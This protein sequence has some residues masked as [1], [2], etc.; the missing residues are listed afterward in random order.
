MLTNYVKITFRNLIRNK[1]YSAVNIGGL[2]I[3]MAVTILIG[4]WLH[5]ELTFNRAFPKHAR[6][7]Q[8]MATQ[9]VNGETNTADAIPIP[10]AD[11]LRINHG[12]ALKRVAL[13]FPPF[14][15]ILSVGEKQV[16]QSGIWAQADLPDML[17]FTMLRGRRDALT[18]PSSVLLA[19]SL[20]TSLFGSAEPMGKLIKLDNR[21]YVTVAGVFQ[22]FPRNT[23][24][25]E[26]KL[27]LSWKKVVSDLNW[28]NEARDQWNT[29]FWHLFVELNEQ[30][31]INKLNAQ[32]KSIIKEHNPNSQTT[33]QLFPMDRWHLYRQFTN[34]QATGGR[35]QIIWL[36]GIIGTFVLLLA[37]INFMNLSTAR[38]EK[39]AQ[40][41]GV[42]KAVGSGR[43][44]LI[45]LFLGESISVAVLGLGLA[46]LLVQ[47]S[48]P[49]FNE[50]TGK[51]IRLPADTPVFWLVIVGF[52]IVTGL[53]AGSYPALY[54]SGFAPGNVLAGRVAPGRFATRPR[55][56]LV[57]IQFTVS[58]A[59]I[60]GTIV[61]FRQIQYA[62]DR[63]VGYTRDGL[64]TIQKNTPALFAMP[65]NAVRN[66]LL[67]TGAVADIAGS[68]Q[69]A[70]D[71][72]AGQS[73]Y[74]WRGKN[75]ALKV[76]LQRV[77]VTH[78]FGKTL[79]WI[80]LQGRDF[81]RNFPTD[82]GAL[83]IN[84]TAAKTLG[85]ANPIGETIRWEGLPH[86][87][88][89]VVKDMVMES[90]YKPIQSAIFLLDYGSDNFITIRI[91]PSVSMRTALARV[92]AVFKKYNPDSPFT[93][94][95][96]DDTYAKKFSD[97]ERVGNLASVFAV[98][99]IFISCLGLFGLASFVAEQR[100]KEIGIRK[101][102]GAS[103]GSLWG[104]LS[105]DFVGLVVIACLIATPLAWYF[106]N[107]WLQQYQ[108]RTELSWWMFAA[109]GAG[110]LIIT[111]LTVSIQSIRA[112][113]Q[114]PVK[115]LRNE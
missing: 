55:Q 46:L 26:T 89:G 54:L 105:K 103:V 97:E 14:P 17:D 18:D 72:P 41:V 51:A 24:F 34:G 25:H 96:I 73:E 74:S 93:Y 115:S 6:L 7:A 75:P 29:P 13:V 21:T 99:A 37:C 78:D 15:H 101:V 77:S 28:V 53:V 87:I 47:V 107:G 35:I 95:F 66:E 79:G 80:I 40:E 64:L 10:L 62:K 109:S 31:D 38:S 67:K 81:S 98:L 50:L 61:V 16:S 104:L 57:V 5:D 84:E 11:A 102:L 22:D 23:F 52:T 49:F 113:L 19:Q 2:A 3:G 43:G 111:L 42:R 88:V 86:T 85:F 58:I 48:L 100:T 30:A 4:L 39:R 112:A 91:S 44:Q 71:A 32:V 82:S 20:A 70:T 8:V 106:L 45:G 94:A 76:T 114:N 59:L 108:Y 68:S 56:V 36:F 83:V 27:V 92:A 12:D 9:T 1:V 90:P 69:P 63:P 33:I 110:A 65:Y 60:S